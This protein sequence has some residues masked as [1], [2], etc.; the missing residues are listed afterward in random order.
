MSSIY[1]DAATTKKIQS[2]PHAH[3]AS[4]EAMIAAMRDQMQTQIEVEVKNKQ[5]SR[6]FIK[7]PNTTTAMELNTD[8]GIL[9]I[10]SSIMSTT[11]I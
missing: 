1:A 2:T 10:V 5:Y 3:S 8:L 9:R 7:P 4:L 11:Y 6:Q